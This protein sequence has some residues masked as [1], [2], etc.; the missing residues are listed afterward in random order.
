MN[1]NINK[2]FINL[3]VWLFSIFLIG[4]IVER[5]F[6]VIVEGDSFNNVLISL[7]KYVEYFYLPF[8]FIILFIHFI[9]LI[10]TPLQLYFY[11]YIWIKLIFRTI[12]RWKQS[13]GSNFLNRFAN[14]LLC[15]FFNEYYDG[16]VLQ[17]FFL[18]KSGLKNFKKGYS[19]IIQAM[20]LKNKPLFIRREHLMKKYFWPKWAFSSV[21]LF[22]RLEIQRNHTNSGI[23]Y[24]LKID[25][26]NQSYGIYNNAGKLFLKSIF[27]NDG[28]KSRSLT[29]SKKLE[30]FLKPNTSQEDIFHLDAKSMPFRWASGGMLPIARWKGK[31][32]Y[33]LFFRDIEPVG[34]N[35]ANGA[36]ESKEEYK[37]L[38]SLIYR[39][40]SEELILLNREPS[41]TDNLPITQK[42]F[43][44]PN[45]LP[46]EISHE[47]T[48]NEFVLKHNMLR[49][50]HDG[51]EIRVEDIGP[52]INPIKTPFEIEISFHDKKLHDTSSMIS[53][54]FFSL[55][56]TEFG[57]EIVLAS[58]FEMDDEDYLM[59]G[60]I[61]EEGPA[62]I[63][64]P[65]M[66][67]SCDYVKDIYNKNGSLGINIE[68]SP[69]L[70]CK[71]LD[72][73]PSS[74]YKIFDKDIEFRK[75]RLEFLEK[76]IKTINS[77]EALRYRAWMKKYGDLFKLIKK[78]NCNIENDKH[79]HLATLC[80]VT[81]K[82]LERMHQNGLFD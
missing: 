21:I 26:R 2:V 23:K 46:N 39:E 61:W 30:E 75:R 28:L 22:N 29:T 58:H 55:N 40:F 27:L 48:N 15:K 1:K 32:W 59:D 19:D 65:I 11:Y 24:K 81:W 42:M 37:D 50:E 68:D 74:E 66:L 18:E 47:I 7:W 80:P 38:Y 35:I 6:K 62:L 79:R 78:S 4:V 17:S 14:R 33:V 34:W 12:R 63:R 20:L 71:L 3:Q 57:I 69:S 76:N 53:D 54:I 9:F 10:I 16:L 64:Q 44:L 25:L 5:L 36:S 72:K 8:V 45:P 70:N 52:T 77:H 73:I 60:E 43:R 49:L 51:I 31:N 67:L 56:P 13:H 82:T 41:L